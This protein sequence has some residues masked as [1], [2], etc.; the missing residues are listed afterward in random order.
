MS[1]MVKSAYEAALEK[2]QK[3]GITA[4]DTEALPEATREAMAQV[5]SKAKARL[6]EL[7][8]LHARS[9]RGLTDPAAVQEEE[10]GYLRERRRIEDQCELKLEQIRGRS[11]S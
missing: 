2:L 1:A 11:T 4:P 3:Q 5:R 8:I 9:L 7:E 6:A 10:Q